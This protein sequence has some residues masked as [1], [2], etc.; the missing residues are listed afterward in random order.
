MLILGIILIVVGWLLGIGLLE[1][2]GLILAVIGAILLIM[3]GMGRPVG[4]RTWF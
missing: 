2:I 1:T 4:G 3:S